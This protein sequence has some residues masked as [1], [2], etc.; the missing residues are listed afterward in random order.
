[1]C[2]KSLVGREISDVGPLP[3]RLLYV[4]NQGGRDEPRLVKTAGQTGTYTALSYCWGQRPESNLKTTITTLLE[5]YSE[6]PVATMP[7]TFRDAV[8]ITRQLGVPYI[9]IDSL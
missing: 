7:K 4:G 2:T 5:R 1:M 3:S 6:I 9:W 8:T